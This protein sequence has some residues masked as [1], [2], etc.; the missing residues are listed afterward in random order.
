MGIDRETLYLSQ[1]AKFQPETDAAEESAIDLFSEFAL[2][3]MVAVRPKAIVLMG[4][5]ATR[6]FFG[7]NASVA[8]LRRTEQRYGE[9]RVIV[10]DH[11]DDLLDAETEGG[12]VARRAKRT[13]WEDMLLTMEALELP[14]SEKQRGF[15]T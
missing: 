2:A 14:V 3:E 6:A 8:K 12:D 7:K 10:T 5:I 15:F 13:L 11:P 4:N 9:A 1:I